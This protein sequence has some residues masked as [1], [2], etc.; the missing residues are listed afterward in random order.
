LTNFGTCAIGSGA[1]LDC[2]A[3][4]IPRGYRHF[5]TLSPRKSVCGVGTGTGDFCHP[6]QIRVRVVIPAGVT[7]I[8]TDRPEDG[9]SG[10]EIGRSVLKIDHSVPKT[11]PF[12]PKARRDFR[13][14]QP[15]FG[16]KWGFFRPE[17]PFFGTQVVVFNPTCVFLAA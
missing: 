7:E 12:V 9:G 5:Q 16:P 11:T 3:C 14:R 8:H 1:L 6:H 2:R 10:L 15:L 13:P 17:R 4:S